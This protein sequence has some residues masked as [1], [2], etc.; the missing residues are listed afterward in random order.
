MRFGRCHVVPATCA[1]VDRRALAGIA[2]LAR[3]P[4]RA[5]A[6]GWMIA[7]AA[8]RRAGRT[9]AMPGRVRSVVATTSCAE[10]TND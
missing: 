10:H 7:A 3:A 9:G 1:R 4:A 5:T 8:A 2:W 6:D